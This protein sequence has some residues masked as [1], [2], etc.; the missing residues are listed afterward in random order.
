MP[1]HFSYLCKHKYKIFICC[2]HEIHLQGNLAEESFYLM[3]EK[4]SKLLYSFCI[5]F[6]EQEKCMLQI[7]TMRGK[8]K[9]SYYITFFQTLLIPFSC[10]LC[11]SDRR[12][13]L[14]YCEKSK[15]NYYVCKKNKRASTL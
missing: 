12:I 6:N 14:S 4:E 15:V 10:N 1:Y 3:Q 8:T 13:I 5:P 9:V 11:Y 7:F 2:S